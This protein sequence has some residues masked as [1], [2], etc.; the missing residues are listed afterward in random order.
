MWQLYAR[1]YYGIAIMSTFDDLC[2]AFTSQHNIK[3]GRVRYWDKKPTGSSNGLYSGGVLHKRRCYD[4]EKEVRAVVHIGGKPATWDSFLDDGEKGINIP[5]DLQVLINKIYT[6]P[7]SP[8]WFYGLVKK[9]IKRY[10]MNFK[11]YKSNLLKKPN[12]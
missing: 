7:D 12:Y 1:K 11:V 8:D 10:K 4:Y 2:K 3:I 6:C 9:I 5:V